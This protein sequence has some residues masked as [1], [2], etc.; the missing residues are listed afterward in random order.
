L[1]GVPDNRSEQRGLRYAM[2][3][4]HPDFHG[5][6]GRKCGALFEAGFDVVWLDVTSSTMYNQADA[7]GGRVTQWDLEHDRQMD[8][9]TYRRF[10]QR[11]LDALF[12]QFPQGKF[13]VNNVKARGFFGEAGDRHLLSG[14]EG[15]H[16][17]TG[18]SM[19]NYGKTAGEKEWREEL[20]ATLDAVKH[21]WR[22]DCVVEGNRRG[23]EPGI[24]VVCVCDVPAGL[25]AG[26]A[27]MV[28]R[29]MGRLAPGSGQVSCIISLA[30]RS[31]ILRR[32]TKRRCRMFPAFTCGAMSMDSS[33]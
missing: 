8:E 32:R 22:I 25:G 30:V 2:Q 11:K 19:E 29:Q 21:G 12:Q 16:P 27:A 28:W 6:L 17:A 20:L 14:S 1:S 7:Y 31:S 3:V 13:W 9:V 33:W 24:P 15:H 4:Q 10:Q 26:C 5:W 18:G 23:G